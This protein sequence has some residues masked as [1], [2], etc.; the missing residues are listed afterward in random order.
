M[1]TKLSFLL[2]FFCLLSFSQDTLF[3]PYQA[4]FSG[5]TTVTVKGFQNNSTVYYTLDGTEPTLNSSSTTTEVQIPISAQTTFKGFFVRLGQTSPVEKVTYYRDNYE[6][7]KLFFKP[8]ANWN[9]SCAY[10]NVE[11]PRTMVD[12]FPPGPQMTSV[13][14]GW[15]KINANFA[16]GYVTFNTC[17]LFSPFDPQSSPGFL[18]DSDIFWDFSEGT[19]TNPPACLLASNEVSRN[20]VVI[21]V[22]PNPVQDL[23][24]IDSQISFIKYEILDSSGKVFQTKPL[25]SKEI[26][27]SNLKSGV[28]YIKLINSD[29]GFHYIKFIKK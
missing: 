27:V 6:A 8:P 10:M 11:E 22:F 14:D 2:V 21:K 16:K 5:S 26:D 25:L 7:P 13:C 1:K 19:I 3:L 17:F 9:N 18:I 12:F 4:L 20:N 15:K 29:S 23:L 28:Y 24:Q